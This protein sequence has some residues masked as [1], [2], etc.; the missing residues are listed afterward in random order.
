MEALGWAPQP[1]LASIRG[2]PSYAQAVI[3]AWRQHRITS[4]RAIEL[5]YGEM[6]ESDL[7]YRPEPDYE[8]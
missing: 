3:E 4:S 5:M 2:P 8:P 7:E 1:D 6:T